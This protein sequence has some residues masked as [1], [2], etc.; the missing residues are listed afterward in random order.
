LK[1]RTG[2][3]AHLAAGAGDVASGRPEQAS[4]WKFNVIDVTVGF[5]FR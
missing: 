1:I 2:V 5:S 3:T 4:D